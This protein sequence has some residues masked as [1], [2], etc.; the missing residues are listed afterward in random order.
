[1]IGVDGKAGPKI[2]SAMN[3]L[4]SSGW[5]SAAA[6]N[7]AVLAYETT[8]NGQGWY[9]HHHHH[10][11]ISLKQSATLVNDKNAIVCESPLG[12]NPTVRSIAKRPA[13]LHRVR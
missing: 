10:A 6:C 11:H 5:L 8:N 7:N 4:C 9:Y 2:L 1:V 12:C 3:Q 13:G